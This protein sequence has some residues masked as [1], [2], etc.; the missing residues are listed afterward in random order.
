MKRKL[1][2]WAKCSAKEALQYAVQNTCI[3]KIGPDNWG[4]RYRNVFGEWHSAKSELAGLPL[5][6][7]RKALLATRVCIAIEQILKTP[8]TM[9]FLPS[10]YY[11]QL[12]SSTRSGLRSLIWSFAE[13]IAKREDVS[14]DC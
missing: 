13:D 14:Y 6:G 4:V 10:R 9:Y 8:T 1:P 12:S 2:D 5:T 11:G 3:E 7:A